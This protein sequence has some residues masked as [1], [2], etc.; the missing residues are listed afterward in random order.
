MD[1]G[2]RYYCDVLQG[3]QIAAHFVFYTD[4]D[5]RFCYCES[6]GVCIE[7]L[8]GRGIASALYK[9]AAQKLPFVLWS[10]KVSSD[11]AKGLW[12]KLEREGY[13]E[14]NP[15]GANIRHTYRWKNEPCKN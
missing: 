14:L 1:V 5:G 15:D 8:K 10:G 11:S 3:E 7:E 4:L 9:T 12:R 13:A 6:A 2:N